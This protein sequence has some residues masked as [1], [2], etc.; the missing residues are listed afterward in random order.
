MSFKNLDGRFTY[1]NPA[2]VNYLKLGVEDVVGKQASD[3]LPL[4]TFEAIATLPR[5][6]VDLADPGVGL[7]EH[8]HGPSSENSEGDRSHVAT[9]RRFVKVPV[10]VS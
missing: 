6:A 4:Q 3:L 8:G 10:F 9:C 7:I 5:V 2:F 1:A